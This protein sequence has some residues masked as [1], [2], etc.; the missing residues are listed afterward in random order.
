M[1]RERLSNEALCSRRVTVFAE[2]EL[3]RVA[4]T[5]Y[6]T[7]EIHS[8]AAH[9]DIGFVQVPLASDGTLAPVE[10]LQQQG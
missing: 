6:G 3:N 8:L 1:S 2:E 4:N 9:L 7:V 5:V 10:K